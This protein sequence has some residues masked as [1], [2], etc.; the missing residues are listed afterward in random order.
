MPVL[1]LGGVAVVT[2]CLIDAIDT[3]VLLDGVFIACRPPD[4]MLQR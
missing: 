1:Y 3:D 2:G 4:V